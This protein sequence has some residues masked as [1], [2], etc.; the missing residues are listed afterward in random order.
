MKNTETNTKEKERE[1]EKETSTWYTSYIHSDT[2]MS[3]EGSSRFI[4]VL[5]ISVCGCGCFVPETRAACHGHELNPLEIYVTDRM[6]SCLTQ[7]LVRWY[8]REL[9]VHA[10][11]PFGLEKVACVYQHLIDDEH[12]RV[13][14]MQCCFCCLE[15][16]EREKE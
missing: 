10:V 8:L 1:K 3:N 13:S 16:R 15:E 12:R 5:K 4:T 14:V 2:K 7:H 9:A 6:A 11:Q